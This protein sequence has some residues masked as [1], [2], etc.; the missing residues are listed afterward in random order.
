[1]DGW[2]GLSP[3]RS[4]SRSPSGDKNPL[5]LGL[6]GCAWGLTMR[7]TPLSLTETLRSPSMGFTSN[8]QLWY[9]LERCSD[10]VP[11]HRNAL[12]YTNS[13]GNY[14]YKSR[15]QDAQVVWLSTTS[16]N[17]TLTTP[18]ASRLT[19]LTKQNATLWSCDSIQGNLKMCLAMISSYNLLST[20]MK[21]H[22]WGLGISTGFEI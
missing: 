12:T 17:T 10:I 3:D 13:S 4:I 6:T 9:R 20:L 21:N 22:V 8:K 19:W 18:L 7:W 15:W 16:G 1:M 11:P 14:K 2:D 5:R